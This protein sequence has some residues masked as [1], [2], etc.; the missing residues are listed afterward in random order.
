MKKLFAFLLTLTISICFSQ[1][2]SVSKKINLP[3]DGGWDYLS[4]DD[5]NQNLFVSHGDVV[6]VVSLKTNTFVA[7]IEDTKGVHGIAIASDLNKAFISCGKDN[8]ISVVDLLNF[9]L[10]EKVKIDGQKPDAILYDKFS[11]EVFI[12]NGKSNNTTIFNAVSNK[13]IKN[14]ALGGKPEFAVTND[15]G[16]IYVNI[17]DENQIKVIDTK[18]LQVTAIFSIL[19]GDEPSGLAFDK[20][21]NR[22]F[23][24]CGNQMM[25]VVDAK[26]GKIIQNIPIG[27][28]CDGVVFDA[29]RKLIFAA[30]G[31]GTMTVVTQN[32]K[33]SYSVLETVSTQK[34]ARTIALNPS[35]GIIYTTTP[36]FGAKPEPKPE[37]PKPR[38]SI[39]SNSFSVLVIEKK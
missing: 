20:S 7:T 4:V 37:N 34:G 19:P 36:E 21:N 32:S 13:I 24:V 15:K 12:F 9:K 23:S 18:T 17:E 26:S 10:L 28:D 1:N 39:I 16:L 14:I 11:K 3:G 29:K 38:L 33:D 22:L 2:F 31:E 30:N 8:S 5:I 25:V 35:S 27:D 6:H